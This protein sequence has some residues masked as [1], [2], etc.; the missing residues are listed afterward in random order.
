MFLCPVLLFILLTILVTPV[1]LTAAHQTLSR[2]NSLLGSMY[3]PFYTFKSAASL[4]L[5]IKFWQVILA[6]L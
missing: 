6:P 1:D 3:R 5:V 4:H 2:T